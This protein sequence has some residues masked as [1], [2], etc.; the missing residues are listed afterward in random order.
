MAHDR[1]SARVTRIIGPDEMKDAGFSWSNLTRLRAGLGF[2]LLFVATFGLPGSAHAAQ[3]DLTVTIKNIKNGN[4]Q[5]P[6]CGDEG[7]A[8]KRFGTKAHQGSITFT[9]K[10]ISTAHDQNSD[11]K[12]ERHFP[13]G[14]STEGAGTSNYAKPPRSKPEFNKARFQLGGGRGVVEIIMHYP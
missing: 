1:L 2:A 14:Y 5:L 6:A 3:S 13:F 10:Q 7:G 11:N 4:G 8:F 9:L 12:I